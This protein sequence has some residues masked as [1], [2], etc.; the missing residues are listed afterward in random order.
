MIAFVSGGARSGKSAVGEELARAWRPP[1]SGG[2]VYL[3][4]ALVSDDEMATR[5][6]RHRRERGE[7]WMT[8]EAPLEIADAL[9]RV[10]VGA[11][12]L[13]DCL[14]LW[15]SQVMFEAG[16]EEAAGRRM[17][18]QLIDTARRREITLVVVSNDLNEDLPPRDEMVWR[19]LAFLQRLHRDLAHQADQ[20]IEVVAGESV[21]WKPL[22]D[23]EGESA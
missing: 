3:A 2:L 11:S 20:V 18:R 4:T 10:P 6:A 23:S 19:Y 15:A 7:G 16:L 14:T 12:V 13:L 9:D 1:E 5:V 22:N 17:L 8:L 21:E